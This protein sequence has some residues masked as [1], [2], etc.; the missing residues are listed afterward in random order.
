MQKIVKLSVISSALLLSQFASAANIDVN[1]ASAETTKVVRQGNTTTINVA[2]AN[3]HG[4]S[5]NAYDKF[6]VGKNGVVFNNRESDADMIINEVLSNEKSR[7]HGHM[8]VDGK[9]AHLIIAN[10]N[11]IACNGCSVSGVKKLTLVAGKT[12]ITPEGKLLGYYD[13]TGSVYFNKINNEA[14][15]SVQRLAVI[16][17]NINFRDSE[18]LTPNLT[19]FAGHELVKYTPHQIRDLEALQSNSEQEALQSNS[20]QT[21]KVTILYGS[22]IKTD[23]MHISTNNTK[24]RNHG[25]IETGPIGDPKT[26]SYM[27]SQLTIDLANSTLTN[28]SKGIIRTTK[29]DSI[30]DNSIIT[31]IG[32]IQVDGGHK[33]DVINQAIIDNK[34]HMSA[35][36]THIRGSGSTNTGIGINNHGRMS[37]NLF[38]KANQIAFNNKKYLESPDI[39]TDSDVLVYINNGKIINGTSGFKAYELYHSG[40]GEISSAPVFEYEIKKP[41]P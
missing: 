19:L 39:S 23:D 13:N 5:Y 21:G 17:G 31:N 34:G 29:I 26:Q 8:R 16:A 6:N 33:M 20:K 3:T 40:N 10:P 36:A 41:L 15:S 22:R 14:F 9:N 4:I 27:N 32:N 30:L 7:L 2:P 28:G 35:T 1:P 37:G 12:V 18:V 38:V 25:E 11:G 24:V